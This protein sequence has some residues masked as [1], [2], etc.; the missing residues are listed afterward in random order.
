MLNVSPESGS[1]TTGIKNNVIYSDF[2]YSS[3]WF[4]VSEV[5]TDNMCFEQTCLIFDSL[6]VS[7][8]V[9]TLFLFKKFHLTR[10]LKDS[11]H[12]FLWKL[13][14]FRFRFIISFKLVFSC[15]IHCKCQG[16]L[17][18]YWYPPGQK[19]LSFLLYYL[20]TLGHIC[21]SVSNFICLSHYKLTYC[22]N[23]NHIVSSS[24]FVLHF[25]TIG[26]LGSLHFHAHLG[27]VWQF[28]K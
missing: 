27:T 4:R 1:A 15:M 19:T 3:L 26:Y 23:Y 9:C 18:V 25:Q 5:R 21:V 28:L 16:S 10:G 22:K 7:S 8:V 13:H 24:R 6:F 11:L 2:E 17:P 14:G 12:V 20:R